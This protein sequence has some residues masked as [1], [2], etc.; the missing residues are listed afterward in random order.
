[1]SN[2]Q[3]HSSEELEQNEEGLDY[4]RL[5][6]YDVLRMQNCKSARFVNRET[7]PS[8]R[9]PV[10]RCSNEQTKI[11]LADAVQYI[12]CERPFRS[13]KEDSI[14]EMWKH[15]P[16]KHTLSCYGLASDIYQPDAIIFNQALTK[17]LD[18]VNGVE[19]KCKKSKKTPKKPEKQPKPKGAYV[20]N[21]SVLKCTINSMPTVMRKTNA[22]SAN[23]VLYCSEPADPEN[24]FTEDE[25]FI[26][27]QRALDMEK[28]AKK[29]KHGLR[30]KHK[31][32]ELQCGIA[33]NKCTAYEW[34]KY[35]QDPLP[36]EVAF[37]M[38]LAEMEDE[39]D[40]EP[41]NFDELYSQLVSCF[42]KNQYEIPACEVYGKCCRRPS[43]R[44]VIQGCGEDKL[45]G[46]CGC[47][48][49]G[50]LVN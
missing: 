22:S 18:K 17:C 48:C 23:T 39:K 19:P 32:C 27:L 35:K 12:G 6:P 40:P 44:R 45:F 28:P 13:E 14:L 31:Y 20:L 29:P 5:T 7:Y 2:Q 43:D 11:W 26:P 16:N 9:P 41:K 34:L 10:S 3:E 30:R 49:V 46:P 24:P 1:M 47:N 21:R 25:P 4:S 50:N 8:I 38:E 33:E 42:E 37:E 36:Y 15:T